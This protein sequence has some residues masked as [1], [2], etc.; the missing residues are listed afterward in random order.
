MLSTDKQ[1]RSAVSQ[2]AHQG[3]IHPRWP[4]LDATLSSRGHQGSSSD[5]PT[6]SSSGQK[7]PRSGP[8]AARH[9]FILAATAQKLPKLTTILLTAALV[10]LLAASAPARSRRAALG[11]E[12]LWRRRNRHRHRLRTMRPSTPRTRSASC[13]SPPSRTALHR[14]QLLF[15]PVRCPGAFLRGLRGSCS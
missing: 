12:S 14:P 6:S 4:T 8:S 3:G 11:M 9:E 1:P 15:D 7:K 10:A 13:Y 2:R 5:S